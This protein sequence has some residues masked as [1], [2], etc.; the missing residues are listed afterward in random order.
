VILART[1]TVTDPLA[2]ANVSAALAGPGGPA[3]VLE[4]TVEGD[5]VTVRFDA[6]RTA[7]EVID[8]LI[9]IETSFVP[10]RGAAPA[11]RDAAAAVAARGLAEPDLDADR[12][13]ET[14]LP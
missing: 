2:R 7:A 13:I 9:A 4:V 5:T 1:V 12:I 11:G 14:Y 8:A 3:G 10:A 6:E